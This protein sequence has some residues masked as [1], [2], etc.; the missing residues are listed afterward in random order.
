MVGCRVNGVEVDLGI[1]HGNYSM[2]MYVAAI[3]DNCIFGLDYIKAREA[4]I[5]LSQG[6][7]VVHG[8]ILKG[9]Y[10]YAEGTSVR[11]HKVRLANDCHPFPNYVSRATVRKKTCDIHLVRMDLI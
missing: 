10:K 1:G 8:T 4:V 9:K 7:F 2:R 11:T 3:T 5:D 6:V